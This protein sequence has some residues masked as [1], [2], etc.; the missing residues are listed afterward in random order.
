MK[1]K[2]LIIMIGCI[3]LLCSTLIVSAAFIFSRS[4][5]GDAESGVITD[6]EKKFISTIYTEYSENEEVDYEKNAY[7]LSNSYN[8]KNITSDE[9][10]TDGS[11]YVKNSDESYSSIIG[12]STFDPD[13]T[14]YVR[15][16]SY[17]QIT[18]KPNETNE[19]IYKK[20][21]KEYDSFQNTEDNNMVYI[22]NG[23]IACYATEKYGYSDELPYL[24]LNQLGISISFKN[25]IDS[26]IRIHIEDTWT[27]RKVYRDG[28]I[29]STYV[30]KDSSIY[31]CFKNDS[32]WKFD[33]NTGYAYLKDPVEAGTASNTYNFNFDADGTY[34]YKV[35]QASYRESVIIGLSFKVEAVQKNRA[36]KIWNIENFDNFLNS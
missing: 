35:A 10:V 15:K 1:K 22:N 20:E 30:T 26:Y 2:K 12:D 11:L 33:S 8:K 24:Y 32:K 34:F 21:V 31:D 6:V 36:Y 13:L 19:K 14:Y 18:E 9:F 4:I 27:S 17:I 28:T 7:I 29:I 23:I 16:S 5:D 3:I 25:T